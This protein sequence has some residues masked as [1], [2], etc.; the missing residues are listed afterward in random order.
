MED[1]K[2]KERRANPNADDAKLKGNSHQEGK[3]RNL[4]ERREARRLRQ[5]RNGQPQL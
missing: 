2:K 1:R 3:V 4:T 5:L